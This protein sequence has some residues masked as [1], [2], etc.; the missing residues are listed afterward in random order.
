MPS[1]HFTYLK[2]ILIKK[3]KKY[4][5]LKCFEFFEILFWNQVYKCID[6]QCYFERIIEWKKEK[7]VLLGDKTI[8]YFIN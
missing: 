4:K 1:K 6:S 8:G 3:R 7:K 2:N 5:W